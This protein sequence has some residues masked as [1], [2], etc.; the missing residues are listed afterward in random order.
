M[1]LDLLLIRHHPSM[2][3]RKA[4]DVI[5]K[6]QVS[7][8]GRTVREPGGDVAESAAVAFDPNRRALPRARVHARRPP[9]GRAM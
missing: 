4:R 2:S 9:R 8:D 1:R 5:E 7:V 6:G 3:R